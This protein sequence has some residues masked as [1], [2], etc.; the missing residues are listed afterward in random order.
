MSIILNKQKLLE[1][2]SPL[3]APALE[4]LEAGLQAINTEKILRS[5]IT[6]EQGGTICIADTGFQC[7][8]Y[9]RIFFIG[10]GKC[11]YDGAKVIEDILGDRLTDGV[12][13]DVKGGVLKKIRSFVGTHPYPS[14]INISVTGQILN[15]IKGVTERDLVLVLV[16][17]GG[18]ALLC[19]PHDMTCETLVDVTKS[20]TEKGADIFELNTVRKH[21]SEIQ[22]GGL[23]K[24]CFPAQV[25]SLIFS[26]VLGNDIG[27]VAS[28]PTVYDETTVADAVQILRKYEINFEGGF[29]ETPKD[30]K[31]FLHV[32]NVLACSNKDALKAMCTKAEELGFR[33]KIA[34]SALSGD[35]TEVGRR[36][37]L[38]KT[39]SQSCVL[40]GGETTV[41]VR[42]KGEGGRNQEVALAALTHLSPGSLFA[43]ISSDGWD[44][45]D[46]AGALVDGAVLEKVRS[47]NLDPA[48]YLQKNDSYNF[49]KNLGDGAICTGRLGSNVS[50]LYILLSK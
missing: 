26:D 41:K 13:I 2:G 44:N 12:V 50:D 36:L 24:V 17:G 14:P 40:W 31:Y 39:E 43:A 29:L 38:Q 27:M 20:L 47:L 5:K 1:S 23:A 37:A 7:S 3:R 30:P 19:L 42:G 22:G 49:F 32:K 33:A 35:A 8:F 21:F 46:H 34:D 25:V 11:A 48:G 15:M 6:L 10:I 16:S 28:G 18:S 9:E 4:I 45:T